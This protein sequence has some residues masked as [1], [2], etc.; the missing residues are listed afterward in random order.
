MTNCQCHRGPPAIWSTHCLPKLIPILPQLPI[1]EPFKYH[2][3]SLIWSPSCFNSSRISLPYSASS[4]YWRLLSHCNPSSLYFNILPSSAS[5]DISHLLP[6]CMIQ[7]VKQVS[8]WS[9]ACCIICF[10]CCIVATIH[11]V[12]DIIPQSFCE[13]IRAVYDLI[14]WMRG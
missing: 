3:I 11:G 5:N 1:H 4:Y 2:V 13:M 14:I 8:D 12:D 9:I 6:L 10:Q 7:T